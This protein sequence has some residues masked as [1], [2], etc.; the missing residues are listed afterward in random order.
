VKDGNDTTRLTLAHNPSHLE[1]VNPVVQ[2]FTRAAQD[3]RKKRG[4]PSQNSQNAFSILIHG[5]AAFIGEGV[6]A[7]TLNLSGLPGYKTGGTIHIIANNLIGYTTSE[8]EGRSTRYASDLA[9]GF[10][11]PIIHVNADDA[12]AC[13][14]AT[15]IA[16]KYRKKFK[17]DIVI[18]L[19]GYRRY[20]HNEMDEP[21]TTQ[22]LLYDEIDTHPTVTEI[23]ATQLLE[24]DLI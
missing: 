23:L 24:E 20:G 14:Q 13:I 1:F 6:V 17:K 9:K 15:N 4:Y 21:R 7:E 16:Y 8:K 19:V 18:V 3:R 22:P 12:I 10:E 11:I 2:G 5:D